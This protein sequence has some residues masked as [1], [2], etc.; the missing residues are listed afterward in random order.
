LLPLRE[1]EIDLTLSL[2]QR[3]AVSRSSSSSSLASLEV[4]ADSDP[5]KALLPGSKGDAAACSSKCDGS[6][7]VDGPNSAAAAGSSGKGGMQFDVHAT[8][9]SQAQQQQ[10]LRRQQQ[11]AGDSQAAVAAAA[12]AAAAAGHRNRRNSLASAD[13]ACWL[14]FEVEDTG[15]GR[16]EGRAGKPLFCCVGLNNTHNEAVTVLLTHSLCV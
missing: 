4:G 13:D 1:Q 10:Q 3:S 7:A 8:S 12:A 6:A 5:G 11:Q 9:S 2:R 16:G 15:E 14:L